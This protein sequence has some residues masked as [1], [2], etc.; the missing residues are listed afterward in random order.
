M[1]PIFLIVF[2]MFML[3]L[4]ST[5]TFGQTDTRAKIVPKG[6]TYVYLDDKGSEVARRRSGQ[7]SKTAGI[8]DCAQVPCPSTFGKD[9][10]CWKCVRRPVTKAQ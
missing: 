2:T 4:G 5:S 7:A 9:I 3:F 8:T 1:K 10:V 6:K